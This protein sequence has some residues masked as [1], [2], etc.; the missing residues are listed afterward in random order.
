MSHKFSKMEQFTMKKKTI[1]D[2]IAVNKE[3]NIIVL[4]KQKR[5]LVHEI[6]A[7]MSTNEY[8][9]YFINNDIDIQKLKNE[10]LDRMYNDKDNKK[11]TFEDFCEKKF[12][13]IDGANIGNADFDLEIDVTYKIYQLFQ[14]ALNEKN[15]NIEKTLIFAK[16]VQEIQANTGTFSNTH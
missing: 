5:Q 8:N 11:N 16:D 6:A 10:Y 4:R 14:K 13:E 15:I 9:D 12:I 1:T 3:E 2:T 7:S